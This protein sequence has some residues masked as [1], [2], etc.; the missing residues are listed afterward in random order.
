MTDLPA[1]TARAGCTPNLAGCHTQRWWVLRHPSPHTSFSPDGV[2]CCTE[3][4]N[5]KSVV[6]AALEG[7]SCGHRRVLS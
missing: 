2:S 1:L 6:G 5:T 4:D 3:E 7:D